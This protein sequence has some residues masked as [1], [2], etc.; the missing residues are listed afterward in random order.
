MFNVILDCGLLSHFRFDG[1]LKRGLHVAADVAAFMIGESLRIEHDNIDLLAASLMPAPHHNSLHKAVA[2]LQFQ[3]NRFQ[4]GILLP[5]SLGVQGA[6]H[7][8]NADIHNPPFDPAQLRND[9]EHCLVAAV[10]PEKPPASPGLVRLEHGEDGR[11]ALDQSQRQPDEAARNPQINQV[12]MGQ[13]R[14]G[15]VRE[16]S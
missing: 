3:L 9:I 2:A 1:G 15:I 5:V 14:V 11:G 7:R 4:D 16:D 12:D 8:D 10:N 13:M 6:R